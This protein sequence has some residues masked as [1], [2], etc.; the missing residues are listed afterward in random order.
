MNVLARAQLCVGTYLHLWG[1]RN[2]YPLNITNNFNK[3]NNLLPRSTERQVLFLPMNPTW[4]G[5]ILAL[6]W[7]IFVVLGVVV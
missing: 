7:K 1:A 2:P 4:K 6:F 5:T 3:L